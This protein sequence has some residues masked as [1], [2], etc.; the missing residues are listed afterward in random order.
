[1]QVE[2]IAK[3]DGID[4]LFVGPWDLGNN[5]GHPVQG[6]FDSEL[7]AA[8][9]RIRKAA[10]DAGKKSGIYCPD[11]SVARRFADQGFQMVR[12]SPRPRR[13]GI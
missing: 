1:M 7:M 6:E 5:I 9:A 13:G 4:V 8:I 2:E 12:W 3:I 11:S 10:Q